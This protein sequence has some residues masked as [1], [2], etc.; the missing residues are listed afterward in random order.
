[1]AALVSRETAEAETRPVAAPTRRAYLHHM[2]LIRVTTFSM[3]IFAHCLTQTNDEFSSI[4]VN[5]TSMLLHVTRNTF[6]ALTGFVLMYQNYDK[7]NFSTITFWRRRLKLTIYPYII[8]S[9]VYWVVEDM[10]VPGKLGQIPT[11]LDDFLRLLSWGLSGFQMYFLFVML[12]VYL[13]FPLVLWL[14]RAT[15][16]HHGP[17]LAGSLTAQ[18]AIASTITHWNPPA[19]MANY[20]WHHYATFVPYQFFILYGAVAAVHRESIADWLSGKRWW[21]LG[22]LLATTALAL[23]S[24]L[25]SVLVAGKPAHDSNSA[26]HPT[27]IP[28][29]IV[30]MTCQYAAAVHWAARWREHTPRFARAVQ[31]A[32]N[33]SFAVFL[34]HV[35][36]IFFILMPS[37]GTRPWILATVPQPWAT[38]IVYL[39]TLAGS[40]LMAEVLRRLPGALYFTG[41]QR[42]PLR[43][44]PVARLTDTAATIVGDLTQTTRANAEPTQGDQPVSNNTIGET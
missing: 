4:P 40:L 19:S 17:L 3:V 41:R 34:V 16:R 18:V 32:S 14:V 7:N 37:S 39:G 21:L 29:V 31:Y 5:S 12:Q 36:I 10:W 20:W 1:M 28:F 15:A 35:L 24:Y 22:S 42:I 27:L 33:R 13:I 38:T 26:F 6:F 30:A 43:R 44:K 2:D 8:W 9:A 11:N 23:G 25:Y